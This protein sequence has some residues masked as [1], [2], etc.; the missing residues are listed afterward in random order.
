MDS[1]FVM[2]HRRSCWFRGPKGPV[3]EPPS[4]EGA[5][6]CGRWDAFD[7]ADEGATDRRPALVR[8]PPSR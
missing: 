2:V 5:W 7:R 3:E 4:C 6:A 8:V 1:E